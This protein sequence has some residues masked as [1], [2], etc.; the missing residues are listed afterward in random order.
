MSAEA[1]ALV[2]T[3]RVGHRVCTITL[4]TPKVGSVCSGSVEWEPDLPTGLNRSEIR[5]YREGRDKAFAE[6]GRRFGG[7]VATTVEF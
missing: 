6:M 2:H 4:P 1:P 3:F 5:Q 7:T